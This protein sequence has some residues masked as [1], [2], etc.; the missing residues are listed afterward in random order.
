MRAK[1]KLKATKLYQEDLK[2]KQDAEKLA[3]EPVIEVKDK[4]GRVMQKLVSGKAKSQEKKSE[5]KSPKRRA[6]PKK[7]APIKRKM[8][9]TECQ[10]KYLDKL[11]LIDPMAEMKKPTRLDLL[12]IKKM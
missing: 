12:T 5:S 7:V 9:F 8:S 3:K 1:I 2:Q 10:L 4:F 6:K 11:I